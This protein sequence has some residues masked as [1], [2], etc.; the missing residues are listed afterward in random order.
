MTS[1]FE[2]VRLRVKGK[3]R[4]ALTR[5]TWLPRFRVSAGLGTERV[6]LTRSGPLV[7]ASA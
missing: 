4:P 1:I 7:L 2:A 6:G 3:T 5:F